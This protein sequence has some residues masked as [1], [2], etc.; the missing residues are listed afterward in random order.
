[1][2]PAVHVTLPI[3]L[4]NWNHSFAKSGNTAG[5]STPKLSEPRHTVLFFFALPIYEQTAGL[6]RY[7][8]DLN[9]VQTYASKSQRLGHAGPNSV[10]DWRNSLQTYA[11]SCA[12]L[13]VK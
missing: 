9:S 7:A 6:Q 4:Q 2:W 13:W 1:M 8:S 11:S 12:N 10:A 5:V 3:G